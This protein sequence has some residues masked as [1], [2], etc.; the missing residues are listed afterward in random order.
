MQ[1]FY[2]LLFFIISIAKNDAGCIILAFK[3]N[4]KNNENKK[5]KKKKIAKC[6]F[7][8]LFRF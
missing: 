5:I 8:F 6:Y 7:L 4:S 2:H 3:I 1:R